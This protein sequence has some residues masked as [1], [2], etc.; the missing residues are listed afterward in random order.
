MKVYY[1]T[2][3]TRFKLFKCDRM[4]YIYSKPSQLLLPSPYKPKYIA[5]PDKT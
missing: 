3:K 4:I 1:M 5:S 2:N